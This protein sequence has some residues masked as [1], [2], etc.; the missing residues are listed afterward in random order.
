VRQWYGSWKRDQAF[1]IVKLDGLKSACAQGFERWHMGVHGRCDIRV[2]LRRHGEVHHHFRPMKGFGRLDS[3]EVRKSGK[4]WVDVGTFDSADWVHVAH[5]GPSESVMLSDAIE[6][7][8]HFRWGFLGSEEHRRVHPSRSAQSLA[9][10]LVFSRCR[11]RTKSGDL[12][13][14]YA[15]A[16]TPSSRRDGNALPFCRAQG[17]LAQQVGERVSIFIEEDRRNL[18]RLLLLRGRVAENLSAVLW[19]RCFAAG[20]VTLERRTFISVGPVI[21]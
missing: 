11:R 13:H 16:C 1:E 17:Y 9:E 21:D 4:N 8:V 15:V 19:R 6:P 18:L 12:A 7:I 14:G 2:N 10:R 3:A 5:V 20:G